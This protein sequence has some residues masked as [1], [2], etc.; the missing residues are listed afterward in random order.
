MEFDDNSAL[1]FDKKSAVYITQ[2]PIGVG[3]LVNLQS[4][5]AENNNIVSITP[6]IWQL[7]SLR[8]VRE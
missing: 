3:D 7:T 1:D 8:C 6:L 4:F 2:V 5:Y